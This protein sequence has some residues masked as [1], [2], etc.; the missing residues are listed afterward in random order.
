MVIRP[1]HDLGRPG[2]WERVEVAQVKF[3]EVARQTLPA[4][5]STA[6]YVDMITRA[7]LEPLDERILSDT[8]TRRV[9]PAVRGLVQRYLHVAR[10][11]LHEFLPPADVEALTHAAA[12]ITDLDW[13]RHS[14]RQ[15]ARC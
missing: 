2:I 13:A 3:S 1:A 6:G 5:T 8:G 7:G 14:S 10:R 15:P 12:H 11:N 9:D 4:E